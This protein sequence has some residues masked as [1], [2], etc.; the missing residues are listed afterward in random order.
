VPYAVTLRLDDAAAA[1]ID[2]LWRRLADEGISDS[3]AA[4]GYRPHL[5][6]AIAAEADVP[7]AIRVLEGFAAT[8]LALTVP[9]FGI[10]AFL[11]QARVLWAAPRVDHALL[12]LQTALLEALAWPA[13]PHYAPGAWVPH[14]TLAEDLDEDALARAARL[15]AA[16]WQ[17]TTATV[18]RIDLVRFRPVEILW[19][20]PLRSR[21]GA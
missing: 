1:T 4:L 19:Q 12:D 18:D 6:F 15:I 9:F 10:G 20:Q 13:H 5:T 17:P 2:A 14:C 8:H 7:A 11:A 3:M 21:A 16:H